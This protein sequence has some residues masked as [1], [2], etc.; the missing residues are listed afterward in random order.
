MLGMPTAVPWVERSSNGISLPFSSMKQSGLSAAGAFGC[1]LTTFVSLFL[2][3]W[4]K[5]KP[6]A[7]TP[8]FIPS[9]T[10]RASWTAMMASK[11]LPP[12]FSISL[13][14]SVASLT[15]LATMP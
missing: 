13:P 10:A 4:H 12:C 14:A 11:A 8:V 5:I 2:K 3:S 9:T 15:A 1:A 6:P 7:P